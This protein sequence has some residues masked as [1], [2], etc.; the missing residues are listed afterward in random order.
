VISKH[1]PEQI[2]SSE[3]QAPALIDDV[4]NARAMLLETLR[5]TDPA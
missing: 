4:E 5:L 1:W 2:H 3:L